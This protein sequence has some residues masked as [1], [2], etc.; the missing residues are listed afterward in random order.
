MITEFDFSKG[1]ENEEPAEESSIIRLT[2]ED[3]SEVL[4]DLVDVV[5]YQGREYMILLPPE[6]ESSQITILEILPRDDG[7]ESYLTVVDDR[8]LGAVYAVF[9]EKNKDILTFVD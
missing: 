6:E 4:F 8:L 5:E 3:G 2:D 1:C 9:R 7:T